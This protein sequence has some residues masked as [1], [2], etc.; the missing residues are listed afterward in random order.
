MIQGPVYSEFADADDEAV[1]DREEAADCDAVADLEAEA[2]PVAVADLVAA[3]EVVVAAGF[4]V[5]AVEPADLVA[6]GVGLPDCDPE[7]LGAAEDDDAL[8]DAL[9]GVGLDGVTCGLDGRIGGVEDGADGGC[10]GETRG[11]DVVALGFGVGR[12]VGE[13]PLPAGGGAPRSGVGVAP[14]TEP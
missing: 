7:P 9:D 6:D 11:L 10:D 8:G 12:V 13:P 5:A 1:A 2:D 3:G 14:S 4:E